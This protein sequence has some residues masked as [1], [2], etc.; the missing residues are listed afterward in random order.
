MMKKIEPGIYHLDLMC[1]SSSSSNSTPDTKMITYF[2]CQFF[3]LGC[4]TKKILLIQCTVRAD[5]IVFMEMLCAPFIWQHS[6]P[7]LICSL[8]DDVHVLD[9]LDNNSNN[10][11]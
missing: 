3:S 8:A 10:S 2:R 9:L 1:A 6:A 7:E 11:S 4:L 5:E